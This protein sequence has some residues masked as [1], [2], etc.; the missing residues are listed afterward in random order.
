MGIQGSNQHVRRMAGCCVEVDDLADRV[1][2]GVGSPAGVG[3]D[4]LAGEFGDGGFQSFLNGSKS[5]LGLPA[6][7]IA[8]VVAEGQLNVAHGLLRE[9]ASCAAPGLRRFARRWSPPLCEGCPPPPK[10]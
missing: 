4:S 9:E 5:R 1:N 7:E 8:A 3:M 2:A 6:E 10:D